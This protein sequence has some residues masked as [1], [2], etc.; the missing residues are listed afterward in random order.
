MKANAIQDTMAV[1]K[2]FDVIYVAGKAHTISDML[3]EIKT[4]V[5]RA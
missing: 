1:D 4:I 5:N 3:T 2:H